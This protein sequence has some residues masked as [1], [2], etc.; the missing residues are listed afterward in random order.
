MDHTA[1]AIDA[2]RFCHLLSV[3][4][5]LGMAFCADMSL[6]RRLHE[7]I[8]PDVLRSLHRAHRLIAVAL[9]AMWLTGLA[10]IYVRTGFDLA[11]FSP[12]LFA[13]LAVVTVLT[14]NSWM[15]GAVAMPAIYRATGRCIAAL[16][17]RQRLIFA[18]AG[19]ASTASWLLALALGSSKVLAVSGAGL[20]FVLVPGSYALGLVCAAVVML[21][22]GRLA[23][24]QPQD[25]TR[26]RGLAAVISQQP[27]RW[28]AD[29]ATLPSRQAG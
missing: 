29:E 27:Q 19:G 14:L 23:P 8:T 2:L 1:I 9:V 6:L 5:G 26:L 20:F 17:F 18:L 10:L 12:K 11:A 16:P 24:R 15:I 3:A 28:K 13:K 22:A 21:G 25:L 4:V 7:P